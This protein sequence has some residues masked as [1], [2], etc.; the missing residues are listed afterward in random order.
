MKNNKQ[1]SSNIE[2]I[3]DKVNGEYVLVNRKDVEEAIELRN[4]VNEQIL[5]NV[6][7]KIDEENLDENSSTVEF[8]VV[9]VN[10]EENKETISE[11][12][13]A[14]FAKVLEI[15]RDSLMGNSWINPI[16]F[17]AIIDQNSNE[18]LQAYI[19]NVE[20]KTNKLYEDLT[21]IVVK[22]YKISD[23]NKIDEISEMY[24]KHDGE[25]NK[26]L[27]L[28][29]DVIYNVEVDWND[30]LLM[31]NK[32]NLFNSYTVEKKL[33]DV[34]HSEMFNE[35][36]ENPNLEINEFTEEE[37]DM[38]IEKVS[39]ISISLDSLKNS[40]LN[41]KDIV[42][43]NQEHISTKELHSELEAKNNDE[44]NEYINDVV[45]Q[46]N[47]VQNNIEEKISLYRTLTSEKNSENNDANLIATLDRLSANS[48]TANSIMSK[49]MNSTDSSEIK[50]LLLERNDV[51]ETNVKIMKK[52][53]K[54]VDL[55]ESLS[56][57]N[58]EIIS[59]KIALDNLSTKLSVA[60]NIAHKNF[61]H[62]SKAIEKQNA[63]LS[64][65][66]HKKLAKEQKM[67][68][69]ELRKQQK[70]LNSKV[71]SPEDQKIMDEIISHYENRNDV[72]YNLSND[73]ETFADPYQVKKFR[74]LLSSR[75]NALVKLGRNSGCSV[76][77]KENLF[78]NYFI[79]MNSELGTI[80][81]LS[82]LAGLLELKRV[83]LVTEIAE[84]E[85]A[86]YKD[87]N[88]DEKILFTVRANF[89]FLK[90]LSA[91]ILVLRTILLHREYLAF[92]KEKAKQQCSEL[93]SYIEW[94]H[95][96]Y[97]WNISTTEA[98]NSAFNNDVYSHDEGVKYLYNQLNEIDSESD[99]FDSSSLDN[100]DSC[101]CGNSCQCSDCDCNNECSSTSDDVP[102][103][104]VMV[105]KFERVIE[106]EKVIHKN[107]IKNIIQKQ[108]EIK[109]TKK[110]DE[111]VDETKKNKKLRKLDNPGMSK[112]GL[113][114]QEII[115]ET[116]DEV[117]EFV[118]EKNS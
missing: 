57:L 61:S 96:L 16:E 84:N 97:W 63:K 89:A 29:D 113:R 10:N 66:A 83:K 64:K 79:L 44:L 14:K 105:M 54:H 42:N 23:Q 114:I 26:Y 20:M 9:D 74:N 85:I 75:I 41:F 59:L 67:R 118:K 45:G 102:M 43:E 111:L 60:Y 94:D 32:L 72:V 31:D 76:D 36:I 88:I 115:N 3:L 2:L 37:A 52:I 77:S 27:D 24:E 19:S 87:S 93:A 1:M 95:R 33:N 53:S 55:D 80:S 100:S 86:H 58:D 70:M 40:S 39:P 90:I 15:S 99:E 47:F 6:E 28:I 104:K 78:N 92:I 46:I 18:K 103:P 50:D 21:S 30:F 13:I 109:D 12:N 56:S 91:E 65:E 110:N 8:N 5:A 73:S 81:E 51:Y 25:I 22:K 82:E 68:L 69:K 112:A 62:Y 98:V 35:V 34:N 107:T 71:M 4:K 116:K 106:K 101:C 108:V 7:N 11:Q 17:L 48:D 49:I 117:K 38:E